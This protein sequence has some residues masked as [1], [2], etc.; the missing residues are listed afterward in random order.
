MSETTQTLQH[1]LVEPEPDLDTRWW[2]DA[3]AEGRIEVPRCRA[4]GRAFFPPQPNC[5]HCGSGDWERIEAA[6]R[7]TVY[8]W[9]VIYSALDERFADEVPYAVLAAELEEG[10]RLFGRWK[11]TIEEIHAGQEVRACIYRIGDTRLLGFEP[12]PAS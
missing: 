5:P 2:W 10:V 1:A 3:L 11:G 4:C 12:A 7:G 9:V 6:G 8:S